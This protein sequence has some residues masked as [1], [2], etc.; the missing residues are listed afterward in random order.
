MKPS[1]VPELEWLKGLAILFVVGIHAKLLDGTLVFNHLIDRGVSIFLVLFGVSAELWWQRE[2]ARGSEHVLR[3]WYV[4]RLR[5][6]LPGYWAA[7]AIWWFVLVTIGA[8]RE[9]LKLALP[10][11]VLSLLG[12]SP[13]MI[14]TWFVLVILQY[15]LIFPVWRG[16]TL[17]IGSVASLALAFAATVA[18]GLY[19]FVII[20]ATVELVGNNVPQPAW[21]YYWVFGPRVLWQITAGI[22]IARFWC[23]RL[24]LPVTLAA[25][26]VTVV[27]IACKPLVRGAPG[28]FSGA[29]RE[30]TFINLID[31]PLTVA[32][33]GLLRWTPLPHFVRQSLAWC[34]RWS[35]G[36]YIGHILVYEAAL[37]VRIQWE[38]GGLQQRMKDYMILLAS[39]IGLAV[40]AERLRSFAAPRL[41]RP[42]ASAPHVS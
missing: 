31:V 11:F 5:R 28:D 25:V 34:G 12:W 10:Q 35:W 24:S 1:R 42:R 39:G 21:Y 37:L 8:P 7:V 20:N 30:L 38:V 2:S 6:M 15:L 9:H 22:F 36:I 41:A 4:E 23:A 40:L 18:S 13:W 17:K 19:V 3:R 32:L 33:L 29:I 16:L 27:A 26:L 14:P